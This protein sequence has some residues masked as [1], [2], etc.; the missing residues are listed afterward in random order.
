[1]CAVCGCGTETVEG[2]PGTGDHRPHTHHHDHDHHHHDH[3]HGEHDHQHGDDA[4]FQ[5]MDGVL[6]A[7]R[8]PAG[9]HLPGLSQARVVRIERD[10]LAKNDAYA[11]DNRMRLARTGTFALNFVSSPGSGKTTLLCRAIVDLKDR[12]PIAVIEGD[13]QTS[14]DAE[15]IRATGVAAVQV[16][17]GRGCHLDAHMVGHA[18]DDLPS[19]PNGLLFIENVGN[20]VCPSGF[21]LGEAHKVV[22]LSVTEGE[23][24]PMKYPDMF[25]ASDLMLLNKS[26]LLPHLDFDVAACMAAALR[27]NPRLQILTVSARTGEG[28]AAFYAWIEARAAAARAARS[29]EA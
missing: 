22:V 9:V 5:R 15:R 3:Q 23:D 18:L 11:R 17:T 16:N 19:E 13:Q 26:D 14:N 25:A 24:K 2:K 7:G 8:G 28:L 10:I 6:D 29:V 1:M 21:D 27:V 4:G 20:L 12:Q